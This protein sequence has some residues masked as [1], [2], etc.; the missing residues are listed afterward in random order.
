MQKK[1]IQEILESGHIDATL[2]QNSSHHNQIRSLQHLLHDLGFSREL[3]WERYGAD[4]YYGASTCAAVKAFCLQ[5]GLEGDGTRVTREIGLALVRGWEELNGSV[6]SGDAGSTSRPAGGPSGLPVLAMQ[7]REEKGR[8][9]LYLAGPMGRV[10]FTVHKKG[11]F[12]IGGQKPGDFI[13]DN[14]EQLLGLGLS[15]SGVNTIAAVSANEGRLDAV[16]TWDNCFLSFGMF[17]WTLGA[18]DQKGELAAL[19]E[20]I[21]EKGPQV[22]DTYF[23]RYGLGSSASDGVLGYLTLNGRRLDTAEGKEALRRHEWAYLFW[24]AGQ[25]PLVQAVQIEHALSRING[26][27]KSERYRIGA[28]FIGDIVTSE[29]GV[30]LVLDNHVNRPG[31]V[32]G[33]LEQA[34]EES[35]L[36]DP[37]GWGSWEEGHF[38][39]QYL[40]IRKGYGKYPMTDAGNRGE[41]I[42]GYVEEGLISER[43]G[44]FSWPG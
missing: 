41:K 15:D 32:A 42:R 18:G 25:D 38:L 21:R 39:N 14:R 27:Y 40:A 44:S 28:F 10:C 37:G 17:Q 3:N 43:R 34:L 35:G 8:K 24:G 12:C 11:V 7:E 6:A 20:K 29:F 4:G 19:L 31:Y 9:R 2:Q 36:K 5:N 22:F 30:A 26:F 23:G 13:R 33:C 16:N 1:A